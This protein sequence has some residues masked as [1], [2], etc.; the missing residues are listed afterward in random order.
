[1]ARVSDLPDHVIGQGCWQPE[2]IRGKSWL[3]GLPDMLN[4]GTVLVRLADLPGVSLPC[5]GVT[6][7][8]AIY[9]QLADSFLIETLRRAV[10]GI[11]GIRT[12]AVWYVSVLSV[13]WSKTSTVD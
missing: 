7:D 11:E 8:N 10:H 12:A 6:C 1:M 13:D 5:D 3:T 2:T 4:P 9:Q